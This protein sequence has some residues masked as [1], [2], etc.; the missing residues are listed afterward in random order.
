MSKAHLHY[1]GIKKL[2]KSYINMVWNKFIKVICLHWRVGVFPFLYLWLLIGEDPRKLDFW[3]PVLTYI[4]SRLSNWKN[5]FLSFGDRLILL[6]YVL[7]SIPVYFLSFFK[8]PACIISSI[9]SLFKFLF[10]FGGGVERILEK[11]LGWIGILFV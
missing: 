8:A 1:L 5:K 10:F 11:L 6:K 2:M 9:E 4:I 3:R 7:S